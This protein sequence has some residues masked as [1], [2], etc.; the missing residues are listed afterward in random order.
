M[1]SYSIQGSSKDKQCHGN[2]LT[3]GHSDMQIKAHWSEQSV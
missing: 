2:P 3:F 1:D